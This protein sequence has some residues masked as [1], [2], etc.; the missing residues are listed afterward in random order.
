MS[1]TCSVLLAVNLNC[2]ALLLQLLVR[3]L[4]D[5]AASLGIWRCLMSR[6]HLADKADS[7]I[8]SRTIIA[9]R[10]Y[11]HEGVWRPIGAFERTGL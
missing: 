6:S 4:E 11:P 3:T 10:T 2:L 8:V 7:S 5:N 1:A 9:V